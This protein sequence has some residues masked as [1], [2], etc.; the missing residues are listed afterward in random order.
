M[1]LRELHPRTRRRLRWHGWLL[2]AWCLLVGL[3]SSWTLLHV[4]DVTLPAARY[5]MTALLM[6]ALGLVLGVQVWLKH[7]AASVRD[8]PSLGERVAPEPAPRRSETA[9]KSFDWGDVLGS[10]A[11]LLSFDEAGLLLLIPALLLMLLG[12]LIATGLLPVMLID[13][14]AGLL[15]EVAV[16]FV[17]GTLIARRVLRPKSEDEAFV[18]ILGK[19]W[20]IGVLMVLV[21]AALGWGLRLWD[22]GL[23]AISQLWR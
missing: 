21:S 20:L 10:A 15:A 17:F 7:F 13:G 9:Q 6:Y 14:L 12:L 18:H 19:T 22:P 1:S 2:T 23:V 5:A 16:Q 8:D 11:D 3:A 4:F